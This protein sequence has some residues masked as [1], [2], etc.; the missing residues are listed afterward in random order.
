MKP[1][2]G[3]LVRVSLLIVALINLVCSAIGVNPTTSV[4]GSQAYEM[5]SI[6]ITAAISLWNC[7]KN[8]SF[9]P[10]A[11]EADA[12]MKELKEKNRRAE[13]PGYNEHD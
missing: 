10:E 4:E 7:W 9:T 3:T 13:D 2:T 5:G 12:Y 11:I 6:L 8:N 1:S